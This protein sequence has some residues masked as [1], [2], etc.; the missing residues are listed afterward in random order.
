MYTQL[1]EF[2]SPQF[3]VALRLRDLVLRQPLGMVFYEE[4][5]ATEYDSMHLG[6]YTNTDLL[7]GVLILKPY[8]KQTLKM[9]QVAVHPNIQGNGVGTLLVNAAEILAKRKGYNQIVLHARETAIKFYQNLGYQIVGD[10]FKEVG[11]VHYK[12]QK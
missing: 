11:I 10:S 12:M 7:V 1:I 4:D 2:A 3:D 8:K 6:C 9:R 5:I